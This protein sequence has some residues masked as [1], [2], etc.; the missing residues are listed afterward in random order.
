MIG[1]T[2]LARYY[3]GQPD[4]ALRPFAEISGRYA[5]EQNKSSL[6]DR[7]ERRVGTIVGFAT[8]ADYFITPGMALEGRLFYERYFNAGFNLFGLSW[9]LQFYLDRRNSGG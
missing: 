5:V 9:G 2:P 7:P 1:L 8:G 3:A 6:A 4:A